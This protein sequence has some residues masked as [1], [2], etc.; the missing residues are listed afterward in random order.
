[1]GRNG[2]SSGQPG[3][4]RLAIG[5]TLAAMSLETLKGHL[6]ERFNPAAATGLDAV[7][8]LAVD[9]ETLLFRVRDRQVDFDLENAVEPDATFF[10]AD[11]DTAWSLLNGTG[12]A[13]DAFMH[14]HFRADGHLMWA[15]ALMAMFGSASLPATPTE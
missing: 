4:Q 1:M 3:G 11:R 15:F 7:F 8:R 2:P 6:A 10:F 12:N 5:L 14:G 9:E 13:F